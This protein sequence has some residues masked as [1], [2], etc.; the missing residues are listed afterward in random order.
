MTEDTRKMATNKTN[1]GTTNGHEFEL[2]AVADALRVSIQAEGTRLD[3]AIGKNL[4][5]LGFGRRGSVVGDD[6]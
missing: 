4:E 5:A 3:A 6:S 2:R 1:S